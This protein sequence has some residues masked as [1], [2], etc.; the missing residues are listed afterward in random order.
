MANPLP[1]SDQKQKQKQQKKKQAAEMR[2]PKKAGSVVQW[3]PSFA[4]LAIAFNI[5][6]TQCGP[7]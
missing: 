2:E 6:H 1:V 7:D 3:T 4:G 5:Y